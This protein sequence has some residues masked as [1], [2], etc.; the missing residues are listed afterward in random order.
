MARR[1]MP[2]I[3]LFLLCSRPPP[4]SQA[5][6]TFGQP[7]GWIEILE[8]AE[9]QG[10]GTRGLAVV[11]Q[12]SIRVVGVARH[13]SGIREI[14]LNG[15]RASL[16][17]RQDGSVRFV[18]Y[19]PTEAQLSE[20]EVLATLNSGRPLV[21]KYTVDVLPGTLTRESALERM[22][23]V[24]AERWAVIVGVSQYA[25]DRITPLQYADQDAQALHD[26]LTSE[27]A[28]L[29]GFK[30]ENVLLLLNE[31][32]TYREIRTA[33]F[34][35]LKA[36]TED[37]LVVIY[38]AGH[39]MPDP[40]RVS[41]LYLLTYDTDV[42]NVSGTA[43]PMDDVHTAVQRT[44]ARDILVFSDACHSAGVAGQAALRNLALNQINELFLERLQASTGGLTVFTAS[45]VNQLSQ[46]GPQWGGGHGVFTH[47]LIQ[48]LEGEAD[49]DRDRIITLGEATEWVR[50]R[51][52]RETRNAQIPSLSQTA[53]DPYLPLSIVTE[54]AE[55][56]PAPQAPEP[57]VQTPARELET[58]P[59]PRTE[60]EVEAPV[61]AGFL[62]PG[63]AAGRSFVLPGLGQFYTGQNGKGAG[64]MA[65][66]MGAL[67]AGF[68]VTSVSEK[69]AVTPP[70]GSRCPSDQVLSS[71]T[72]RPLLPVGIAGWL[73]AAAY[74]AYDAHKKAK[75]I[76]SGLA[77]RV[78]G[79][80]LNRDGSVRLLSPT[81]SSELG[82]VSLEVLR[83]RF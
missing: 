54:P 23:S 76:N 79:I 66:G 36:A 57:V 52:R 2:L 71:S 40:D 51:V 82:R 9:W 1:M 34:T 61:P 69:C 22:G 3:V 43:F 26:F 45:Q 80:A 74:S 60:P 4:P 83:L 70:A 68:L 47:Y 77:A 6:R 12:T 55:E 19:I 39:G 8:P 58:E 21:K 42:D 64:I 50:D 41:N 63:S 56:V 73:A 31:E 33:L 7:D 53:F 48:A 20:V 11:P 62:S 18:G 16:Q 30:E 44:Y 24:L 17:P 15:R 81:L 49:M 32:A 29:G 10:A 27:R 37:D 14:Q 59:T 35:F 13:A 46:E 67:A 78:Q 75:E 38:F 72:S 28:G 65:T 25:D 5:Q